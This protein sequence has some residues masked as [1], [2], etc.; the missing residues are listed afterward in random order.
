LVAISSFR[1]LSVIIFINNSVFIFIV[2]NKCRGK[3]VMGLMINNTFHCQ[4]IF[5]LKYH[6]HQCGSKTNIIK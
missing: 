2:L 5:K 1:Q 4:N 3:E 6:S